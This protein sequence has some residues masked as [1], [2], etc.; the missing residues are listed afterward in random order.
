[1]VRS[2]FLQLKTILTATFAVYATCHKPWLS[3]NANAETLVMLEDRK[4]LLHLF[5][6]NSTRHHHPVTSHLFA[7]NILD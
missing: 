5:G 2:Q 1:M 7:V 6:G 4:M 3:S